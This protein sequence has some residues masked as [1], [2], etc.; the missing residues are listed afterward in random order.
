MNA[1]DGAEK[2]L[3]NVSKYELQRCHVPEELYLNNIVFFSF[4]LYKPVSSL[5]SRNENQ[6]VC[7]VILRSQTFQAH[8]KSVF[9]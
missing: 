4:P 1:E 2:L 8:R 3:R 7:F 5:Q 6:L 9:L